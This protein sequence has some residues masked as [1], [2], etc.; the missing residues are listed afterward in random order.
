MLIPMPIKINITNRIVEFCVK[1]IVTA[2]P[3]NG[4][5][6]GVASIV[7]K[8]PLKKFLVKKLSPMDR[9][10]LFEIKFGI[11]ISY[12]PAVF[13]QKRVNMNKIK[14]KK[15]GSWNCIPHAIDI[16]ICFSITKKRASEKNENIIPIA[17]YIKLILILEESL[18]ITDSNFI[19]KTGKTQGIKFRINPPK[20]EIKKM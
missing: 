18:F 17:V 9:I 16:P 2:D 14:I 12:K 20:I 6:H 5:V 13:R 19:D 4:A 15:Y 11:L 10:L 8:K 7:A 1:A 3:T